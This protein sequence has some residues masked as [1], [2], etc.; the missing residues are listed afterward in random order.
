ME[1]ERERETDIERPNTIVIPKIK[2]I[3]FLTVNKYPV[4]LETFRVDAL[5]HSLA[6]S[7]FQTGSFESVY[8]RNPHFAFVWCMC[9]HS[10][11]YVS[12]LA[13]R[14]P[15]LPR[16]LLFWFIEG[17]R[18]RDTAGAASSSHQEAW[19]TYPN[20]QFLFALTNV[21]NFSDHGWEPRCVGATSTQ[22]GSSLQF[23]LF[24]F[25]PLCYV[26]PRPAYHLTVYSVWGQRWCFQGNKC[27]KRDT[28][29]IPREVLHQHRPVLTPSS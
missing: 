15:R 24:F 26:G 11:G 14:L 20:T 3:D 23:W 1:R 17:P 2:L 27:E 29:V 21:K 4:S 28:E 13:I 6:L 10:T 5:G 12:K 8:K 25:K 16:L 9:H 18:T 19:S 22:W 7:S